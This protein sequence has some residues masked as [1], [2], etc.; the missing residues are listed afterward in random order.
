MSEHESGGDSLL[1]RRIVR[2]RKTF[3]KHCC[4]LD[5]H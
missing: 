2:R 3:L 4:G 1:F 5:S